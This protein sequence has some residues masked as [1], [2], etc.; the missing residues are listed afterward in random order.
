MSVRRLAIVPFMTL[1]L[2]ST[3]AQDRWEKADRETLR[4]APSRFGELPQDLQAALEDRGCSIPQA[5]TEGRPHNVVSGELQRP[6][7]RDWAVL[8]SI[9]RRS[10]ILV[11]WSGSPTSVATISDSEDKRWLQDFGG[12]E[13][14]FSRRIGVVSQRNILDHYKWYDGAKPPPMDHEGID[15]A[16]VGKAS[17]VHYW[18]G[19]EWLKLSGS[20]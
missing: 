7:Q 12:S 15:D 3:A 4:L 13:I 5:W 10:R 6:G 20:D 16:Y 1:L 18:Y 9:D 17:V 11:F 2:G 19:D 14:G 8:C